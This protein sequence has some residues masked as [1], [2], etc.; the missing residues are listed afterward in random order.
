MHVAGLMF[1]DQG[2][3]WSPVAEG[4]AGKPLHKM[5]LYQLSNELG[6]NFCTIRSIQKTS[7]MDK[8]C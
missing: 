4:Y 3:I 7:N 5:N 8:N 6:H 2:G 1:D